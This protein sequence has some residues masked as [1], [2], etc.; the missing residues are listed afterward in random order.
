MKRALLFVLIV[1]GLTVFV[2]VPLATCSGD[3]KVERW[4][5]LVGGTPEL[6]GPEPHQTLRD[7]YYFYHLLVYDI[8]ISADHVMYL[9]PWLIPPSEI[10]QDYVIDDIANST[11]VRYYITE[12]LKPNADEDDIVLIYI[13]THGRG[14]NDLK[15]KIEG[16][17]VT[18][19][20]DDD[21]PVANPSD[22]GNEVSEQTLNMDWNGDGDTEDWVGID[23]GL[24]FYN[25]NAVYWDDEFKEDLD[26]LPNCTQIVV[27]QAC[28]SENETCFC[29]GF[30][31]DLS[32]ANRVIVTSTD[33]THYS[34]GDCDDDGFAEFS[35]V[36]IDALHGNNTTWDYSNPANPIKDENPVYADFDENGRVSIQEAFDYALENDPYEYPWLDCDGDGLPTFINETDELDLDQP[37]ANVYIEVAVCAMKTLTDGYF[38][39]PNFDINALKIEFLFDDSDIEGDQTGG[40]S[41]YE[42]ISRW[43]DGIV[44]ASDYQFVKVRVGQCEG[45][46]NWDYMADIKPD[47]VIDVVDYQIV[48]NNVPSAGNYIYNLTGVTVVFDTEDEAIPDADGCV[49]IPKDATSF[50]VKR[51][52]NP[53]GATITFW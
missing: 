53:M 28:V 12:W 41:P 20:W 24:W 44:D 6:I 45:S 31:D 42:T 8:G 40:S 52:G 48:R 11:S 29:G 14:Y 4:V 13:F 19:S 2:P 51:Y 46:A 22:E 10:L 23:E 32:A 30:I 33:E 9:Y 47:G 15:K 34:V 38:Y 35:E 39:I 25:D 37:P 43:P 16:G 18:L 26:E 1:L 27:L 5:L 49:T 3:G 17:N 21:G 7:T 50:T 36:F